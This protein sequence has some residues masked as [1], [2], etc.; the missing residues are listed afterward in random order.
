REA[1]GA[2]EDIFDFAARMQESGALNRA[3][4]EALIQA[5]AFESLHPNRAQLLQGLD[6]VLSYAQS[7]ARAKSMGQNS[8]FDGGEQE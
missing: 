1:N 2:F 4:L 5:G 7:V 8:L 3:T 6:A